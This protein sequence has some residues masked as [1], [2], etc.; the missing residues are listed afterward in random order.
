MKWKG[1]KA[2]VSKYENELPVHEPFAAGRAEPGLL[3]AAAALKH[4]GTE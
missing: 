1:N 2:Q 4:Q 3:A